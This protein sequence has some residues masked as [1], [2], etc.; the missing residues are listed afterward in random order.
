[1]IV[2]FSVEEHDRRL[3]RFSKSVQPTGGY[4][5]YAPFVLL[6]L[7]ESDSYQITEVCLR[8]STFQMKGTDAPYDFTTFEV[9]GALVD[10]AMM[11]VGH[12]MSLLVRV[13]K[14]IAKVTMYNQRDL[15]IND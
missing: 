9:C 11:N 13:T 14:I 10:S 12:S 6:D 15:Q 4:T 7:L 1:V 8:N 3:Q 2:D 5:V